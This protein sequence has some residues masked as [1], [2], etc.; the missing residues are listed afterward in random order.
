[1]PPSSE[2]T[3]S[4]AASADSAELTSQPIP[5]DFAPSVSGSFA[6]ASA[7]LASSRSRMAT[8]APSS[9][10]RVAVPKPMRLR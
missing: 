9:A 7:A 1:M 4:T 6:A 10:N 8:D 5:T 3:R 2:T